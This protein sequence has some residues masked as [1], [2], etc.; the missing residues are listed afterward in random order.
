VFVAGAIAALTLLVL[1][2]PKVRKQ[3]EALA[4]PND[5]RWP[6]D[7]RGF[8]QRRAEDLLRTTHADVRR[9]R[10]ARGG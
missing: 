8:P 2:S 3:A 10:A 1:L 4:E 9:D 7:E 6:V 5:A